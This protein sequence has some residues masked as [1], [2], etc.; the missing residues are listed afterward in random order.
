MYADREIQW[1]TG[2][3]DGGINGLGGIPAQVG[4]NKG[5]GTG[6]TTI[7][8]SRTKHI[9]K[10]TSASNIGIPGILVFKVSDKNISIR[11]LNFTSDNDNDNDE[12]DPAFNGKVF[13][14]SFAN[15][16]YA[17]LAVM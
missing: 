16:W 14:F 5:D 1:T 3:A 10:V 8:N 6:F 7:T 13:I 17:C 4:F 2:D 9:I 12:F 15:T 11:K